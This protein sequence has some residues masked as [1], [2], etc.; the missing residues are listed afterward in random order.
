MRCD[1]PD[2]W[3]TS[4]EKKGVLDGWDRIK[5]RPASPGLGGRGVPDPAM[6]PWCDR[7][8]KLPGVCTVQ[9]CAGHRED[10]YLS[11]GHLWLRLSQPM[12]EAF[13]R[14]AL[15]L[16]S[17][18]GMEQVARIYAPWG[19]EVASITF[20]GDEHNLLPESMGT[21]LAFLTELSEEAH[22]DR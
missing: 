8:N 7:V 5:R 1:R 12:S 11:S 18:D 16:A 17:R 10:G 19:E 9:S 2:R 22:G 13:D 3:L 4:E 21:I 20:A 14:G 6:V 15:R